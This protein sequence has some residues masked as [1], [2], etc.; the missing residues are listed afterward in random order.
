MH[1]HKETGSIASLLLAVAATL[2][3][4]AGGAFAFWQW[5][6]HSGELGDKEK[7]AAIQN[8]DAQHRHELKGRFIVLRDVGHSHM[9]LLGIPGEEPANA[10]VWVVLNQLSY[11]GRVMMVPLAAPLRGDCPRLSEALKRETPLPEV[12]AALRREMKC[13]ATA[14]MN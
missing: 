1:G 6:S 12:T 10:V 8:A 4:L 3:I 9:T 7:Y 2:A 13:S 14:T 11:E 5:F